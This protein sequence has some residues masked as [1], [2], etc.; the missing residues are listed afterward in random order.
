[1]GGGGGSWGGYYSDLHRGACYHRLLNNTAGQLKLQATAT[2]TENNRECLSLKTAP[3]RRRRR[4]GHS[5]ERPWGRL[6]LTPSIYSS[7]TLTGFSCFSFTIFLF[8]S[9]KNELLTRRKGL[10]WRQLGRQSSVPTKE[11]PPHGRKR[12]TIDIQMSARFTKGCFI[13][14]M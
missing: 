5:W 1:M 7:A 13:I 9:K 8:S 11:P 10:F 4:S 6:Q 2:S 14:R 3:A 12:P